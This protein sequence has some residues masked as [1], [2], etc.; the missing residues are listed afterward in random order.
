MINI[1]KEIAKDIYSSIQARINEDTCM[2]SLVYVFDNG[3][4]VEYFFTN[5]II[6]ST[7]NYEY[8]AIELEDYIHMS[9]EDIE[10]EL[11]WFIKTEYNN[12]F[13]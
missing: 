11:N 9:V 1:M 13:N 7:E 12:R 3:K 6:C 2:N 8:G 10:D 5:D 4:F